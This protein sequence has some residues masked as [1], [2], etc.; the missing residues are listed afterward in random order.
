MTPAFAAAAVE[1][2][3]ATRTMRR[4]TVAVKLSLIASDPRG[5]TRGPT[6]SRGSAPERDDERERDDVYNSPDRARA[7]ISASVCD[8]REAAAL[9]PDRDGHRLDGR[10][11]HLQLTRP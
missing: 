7:S 8:R 5:S 10:R 6:A 1:R 11:R 2:I 9:L 4:Q 3:S